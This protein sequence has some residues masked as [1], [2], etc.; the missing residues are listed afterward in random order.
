MLRLRAEMKLPG[1]AWLE[2]SVRRDERGRTVYRQR[3][4]FRPFGL[5]GQ[6]YWWALRPFHDLVFGS[7]LRRIAGGGWPGHARRGGRAP[8]LAGQLNLGDS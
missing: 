6:V 1:R 4:L 7:M 2:F 5:V 8:R 3:A